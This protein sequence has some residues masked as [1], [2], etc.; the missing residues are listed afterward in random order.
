MAGRQQSS[1][2]STARS[3][4]PASALTTPFLPLRPRA[5]MLGGIASTAPRAMVSRMSEVGSEIE[6]ILRFW[7]G[8]LQ[9]AED[10]DRSKMKMW[11]SGDAVDAEIKQ[12]FGAK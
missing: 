7:F 9:K 4:E 10:V 12:R 1:R 3:A 8:G 5:T 11:W 6:D 2:G